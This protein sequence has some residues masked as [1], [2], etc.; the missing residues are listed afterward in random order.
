MININYINNNCYRK[1]EIPTFCIAFGNFVMG[2]C[3]TCNG[4]RKFVFIYRDFKYFD[5]SVN[6]IDLPT[7]TLA[8]KHLNII[9]SKEKEKF[10][11]L[12]KQNGDQQI[13]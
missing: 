6:G 3:F 10:E 8:S 12:Y 2:K 9:N 1:G 11:Y 7:K 13:D 4:E 5:S